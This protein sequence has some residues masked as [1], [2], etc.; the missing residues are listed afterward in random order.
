DDAE[1]VR[2]ATSAHVPGG[3]SKLLK[4]VE[5]EYASRGAKR[6]ITFADLEISNGNLYHATGFRVDAEL[7]PDYKYLIP[8]T[9]R[10]E[11]KFGFRKERFKNDPDLDYI[12]GFTE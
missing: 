6:I 12:D 11:H 5:R 1:L 3:F 2:Y 10:R 8:T 7:P 9:M 4:H